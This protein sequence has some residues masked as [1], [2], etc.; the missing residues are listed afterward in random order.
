[1]LKTKIGRLLQFIFLSSALVL[2]F[3]T[4]CYAENYALY[5]KYGNNTQYDLFFHKY[6]KQHFGMAFDWR[7]FK[8]QAIAESKLD[9]TAE[10][11][12]GAQGV[13][14]I[15]P[16]TFDE[17]KRRNKYV[18]GSVLDP[19]VNIRAGI[20]YDKSI[21]R[22]WSRKNTLQDRI[23]F[24]MASYN[25]GR[26]HIINAQKHCIKDPDRYGD[27]NS[28]I[29][30]ENTL[31]LITGHHSKETKTYVRRIEGIRDILDGGKHGY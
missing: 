29:C 19:K 7:N 14:Q 10:S 12:V 31:H 5:R 11:Y 2:I 15:M 9:R 13:M 24:M 20:W 22:N 26:G 1:M 25:A 27:P 17:I 28:W 21:W 6:S 4:M 30:I 23:N 16:G 8:A 18:K 3:N